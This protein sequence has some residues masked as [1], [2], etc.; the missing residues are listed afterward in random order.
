MAVA[1]NFGPKVTDKEIVSLELAKQN[2]NI[3]HDFTDELFQVYLSGI[4]AEIENFIGKPVVRREAAI[5]TANTWEQKI[6]LPYPEVEITAIEWVDTS[7]N[8]T[9]LPESWITFANNELSLGDKPEG[10]ASLK[11]TAKMGYSTIPADIVDAALLMFSERETYR[12][13]RPLKYNLSAQ[14]M[15]RAYKRY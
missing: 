10:F 14:N 12:E 13:N 15:L 4:E 9:Q 3:D 8:V 11:I 2:S 6:L 5:I 7:G 1:I